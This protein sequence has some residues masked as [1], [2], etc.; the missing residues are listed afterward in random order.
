VVDVSRR[1]Q[2]DIVVLG[3]VTGERVQPAVTTLRD[4]AARQ[5]LALGGAGAASAVLE[6][7]GVLMQSGDPIAEAALVSTI[8]RHAIGT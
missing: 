6:S 3:A 5:R 7:D 4:L 8:E 2:P 1:L